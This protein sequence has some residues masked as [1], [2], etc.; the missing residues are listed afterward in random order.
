M[1]N[2]ATIRDVALAASVSPATVSL[3]LN[4]VIDSRIPEH[5]AQRVRAA[6]HE[7]GY[8]PNSLARGLRRRRSDTIALISDDVASTPFSV[9]MIEAVHE[10]AHEHGLLLFLIHTGGD[11]EEERAAAATLRRQQVDGVLFA[12]MHHRVVDLP[13]ALGARTVLLDART[14][15]ASVPA[16]V[17]DERAGAFEAVGELIANGHRRIGFIN[18]FYAT[19]AARLR[20]AGYRD[21][22]RA[23]GIRFDRRLVVFAE[24]GLKSSARAALALYEETRCTGVFCF[25]DRVA[26]GAGQG[27]RGRG[28]G[29]PRDA[30]IVGF[31]DQDFV[32]SYAEPPLTTVALPHYEMGVWAARTL[33][34]MIKG[35]VI[36][37][38]THLMPCTLVR[39]ESV[40][41]PPG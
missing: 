19:E 23:A 1:R 34:N 32:A 10:V 8:A 29:V 31:D 9:R 7:L 22:L 16:I 2:T 40:G 38:K 20:L 15:R 27:L 28:L 37:P 24:P 33:I 3:V 39:R 6:A 26:V 11:P 4:D 17:P 30:S 13:P 25:N 36:A 35:E 41:P 21:A 18:D 12:S 14:A 5:T